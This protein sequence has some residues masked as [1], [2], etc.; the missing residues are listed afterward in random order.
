MNRLRPASAGSH[1]PARRG[2]STIWVIAAIPAVMTM[3]VLV[4][5]I[6]NIWLARIELKN[7][8]D[9]AALST[10]KSWG[11]GSS[12]A[13]ARLN[14]NDAMT[15][16]TVLG[17]VITL[18]TA[19]GGCVNGNV[20]S[21]GEIVLGSITDNGTTNIFDCA[22]TPSCISGTAEVV[23]SVDTTGGDTFSDPTEPDGIARTTFR[24]E[25]FEETTAIPVGLTLN[26]ITFELSAMET[27]PLGGGTATADDGIFDLRAFGTNDVTRSI[28]TP[29]VNSNGDNLI[30][31]NP[32]SVAS[33]FLYSP[34]GTSPRALTVTFAGGITSSPTTSQFFF[35]TDTDQVGG[36]TG[37]GGG[38]TA[39]DFGGEFGT[40]A[41]G[42]SG[43][44][45]FV[46]TGATVRVN[47]SGQTVSGTLVRISADRSEVTFNV[48]IASGGTGFGV[49]ARKT[50]QVQSMSPAFYGLGLGPYPVTAESFAQFL[51][52]SGPPQLLRVTTVS[53]TCP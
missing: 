45:P 13:Q 10:V 39:Q 49:R 29:P 34:S 28:G 3:F 52:T 4:V 20:S 27:T 30:G 40:D 43:D 2:L 17:S 23:V 47:I 35:G 24:I 15:T 51:C 21:T 18:N 11:E 12:T 5:D 22:G 32:Q 19:E 33:S 38:V 46:S 41:G 9:A 42:A 14:G 26:S 25:R 44:D 7:A 37:G 1:D 50:I 8:L 6:A 31:L 36:D 53:C 16:N 48:N